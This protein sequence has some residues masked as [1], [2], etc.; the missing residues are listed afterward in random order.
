MK[1]FTNLNE[2]IKRLYA[3]RKLLYAL[4]Q[5]RVRFDVSYEEAV[6]LV[7]NEKNL[8][9]LIDYGVIR[10]EGNLIE[11]EETYQH[12]FEEVLQLNEDITSSTVEENLKQLRNNIDFY[13]KERN[14]PDAQRKYVRKIMR[15]MRNISI[16]VYTKTI[17][18]KQVINDTFRQ[19]R[20]YEIKRTKLENYL[21]TLE[22]I[23]SLIR[24]TERLLEERRDTIEVLTIDDRIT[25]LI[26]DV[27]IQFK[28]VFH[29]LIELER[30]IRDYLNQIDAH[31]RLVKHIR[32]LKYLKDQLTWERTT[33][34]REILAKYNHLTLE[35]MT[36]YTTKVSL[37]FLRNSDDAIEIIDDARKTISRLK[38]LKNTPTTPL[39]ESDLNTKCIVEDFVDTD[40]V[41]NAF[42]A[43]SQDL[44]TFVINYPYIQPQPKERR[45]EYYLEIVQNHYHRLRITDDWHQ[46]GN[47]EYPLIYNLS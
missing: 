25:R 36:Y 41:A 10:Q 8:R 39:K 38:T 7:D 21:A 16:Q 44:Y 9:L 24:Q 43:S 14:H 37:S 17:E 26:L 42:F 30:T 6:E 27:K 34:V 32:K 35:N 18:L 12:F 1:V 4:F 3:E 33:N 19:E 29:S 2:L 11:L 20:N 45:V 31:N 47:V 28:D 23:S 40:S 13:L 5:A 15:S 46:D 22:S